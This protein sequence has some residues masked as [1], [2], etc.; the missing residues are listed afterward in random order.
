VDDRLI[1]RIF[2]ELDSHAK[3]LVD[4]SRIVHANGATLGLVTKLVISIIIF[5]VVTSI[6]IMYDHSKPTSTIVHSNQIE[7]DSTAYGIVT[8]PPDSPKKGGNYADK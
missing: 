3:R 1:D 7:T 6:G 5:I 8:D 2:S 4:L